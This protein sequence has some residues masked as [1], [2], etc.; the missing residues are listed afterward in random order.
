[1]PDDR[2]GPG[3]IY[4]LQAPTGWCRIGRTA[5]VIERFRQWKWMSKNN[6]YELSPLYLVAVD[7]QAGAEKMFHAIFDDKRTSYRR[8]GMGSR[9]EWFKLNERDIVQFLYW[10]DIIGNETLELKGQW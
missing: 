9:H 4:L 8:N 3:Y 2:Y 6:R 5:N 7:K 10:A 1:M